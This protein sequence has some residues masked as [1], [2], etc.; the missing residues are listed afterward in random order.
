M[1]VVFDADFDTAS[2]SSVRRFFFGGDV[3]KSG[4][5]ETKSALDVLC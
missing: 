5:A 1:L 2:V 3:D 4:A